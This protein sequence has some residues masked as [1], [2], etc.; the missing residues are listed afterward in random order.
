MPDKKLKVLMIEK[1]GTGGITQYTYKLCNALEE[2]EVETVLVTAQEYELDSL[3][4]KFKIIKLFGKAKIPFLNIL[5]LFKLIRKENSD[6]IHFQWTITPR[7]DPIYIKF[8]RTF[9]KGKIVYTAHNVLPH[10]P[11]PEDRHIYGKIYKHVDRIIVHSENNKNELIEIF[12]IDSSKI[13]V[14]PLGNYIFPLIEKDIPKECAK[15]KLGILHDEKA[16][17]FFGYIREYKGLDYLIR[18]FKEVRKNIKSK[19]VIAGP[20]DDFSYY[21]SLISQLNLKDDIIL[22]LN[23][24]SVLSDK[25]SYYF[26]ATDAVV[27]PYIKTYQSAVIQ[28]AYAF[29]KPV[30]ATNTGSLPEVIEDGKSGYIIP[31]ENEKA[32]TESIVRLLSDDTKI[33]E[34]GEYARKLAETKFSWDNI[35]KKT[36]ELYEGL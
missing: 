8:L 17:L 23:Y 35:A 30:I 16:V 5:R 12:D 21:S 34:M 27:L 9:F 2:N 6:V 28:I 31:P 26:T 15:E 25:L 1:W 11:K 14:I 36:K 29:G 4:R 13:S 33:Q 18:S 7:F 3:E 32:L 20:S 24:I 10:E 22:D 19:L